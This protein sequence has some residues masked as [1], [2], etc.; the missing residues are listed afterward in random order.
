MQLKTYEEMSYE[1]TTE[2]LLT[3][4]RSKTMN[5]ESDGYFRVLSSFFLSQMSSNMRTTIK[6]LH[7]GNLPTNLFA[8]C[9]AISGSGWRK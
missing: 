3:I 9:L 5:T 7:K 4:L 6:T 8:S 2:K 1:P